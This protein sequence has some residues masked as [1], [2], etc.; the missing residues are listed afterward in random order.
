M[1]WPGQ[2]AVCPHLLGWFQNK[3]SLPNPPIDWVGLPVIVCLL[4]S[5]GLGNSLP[6]RL[7]R[8]RHLGGNLDTCITILPQVLVG[9]RLWWTQLEALGPSHKA[10]KRVIPGKT[11]K[12]DVWEMTIWGL[13]Q[14]FLWRE[15]IHLPCSTPDMEPLSTE[16]ESLKAEVARLDAENQ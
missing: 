12:E 11:G 15:K 14:D 16:I 6:S 7:P 10:R 1:V 13:V 5:L 3:H 4:L 2:L 9:L 8:I